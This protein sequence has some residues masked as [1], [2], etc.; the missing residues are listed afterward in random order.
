MLDIRRINRIYNE[1]KEDSKKDKNT[2]DEDD[3]G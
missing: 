1:L 3:L 2:I